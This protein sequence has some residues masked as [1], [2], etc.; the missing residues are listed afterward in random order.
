[1]DGAHLALQPRLQA[2]AD[3]VTA[4]ARLVD[5]GTDHGYLPVYL[6]QEGAIPAAIATDIGQAPLD[7]A[8]RTAAAYGLSKRLSFRLC[9]GLAA[10]SPEEVDTVVIAGMGGETIAAILDAVPWAGEK[11]LLLQPMTRS[12]LLRPWLAGHNYRIAGET[13]V[14]D[15]GH[16]YPIL[17]ASGG[18]M[19]PPDPGQC[20]YGYASPQDPLFLPYL[21]RWRRRLE[22]AAAGLQSA[23]KDPQPQ[24]LEDLRAALAALREKEASLC[25][26]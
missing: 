21:R 5:V 8:R 18:Q 16:I 9:D 19:P 13:L 22:R 3:L 15:K 24:R 10:V 6:L 23:E 14:E 4:G 25:Q 7:H 20:Y 26:P 12:E 17:R 11:D 1:M 2:I